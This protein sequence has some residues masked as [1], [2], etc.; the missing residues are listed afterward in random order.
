MAVMDPDDARDPVNSL[1]IAKEL[2]AM[3]RSFRK[4]DAENKRHLPSIGTEPVFGYT[5]LKPMDG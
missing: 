3:G 5:I 2:N 1:I 4:K